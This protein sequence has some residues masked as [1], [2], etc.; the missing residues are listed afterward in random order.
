MLNSGAS[1]ADI[2]YHLTNFVEGIGLFCA[3]IAPTHFP[4][5]AHPEISVDVCYENTACL[6]TWQ[7]AGGRQLTRL[8]GDGN[9]SIIGSGQ[10]HGS[11][12]LQEA[13][14]LIFYLT[15]AFVER[16]TRDLLRRG[17]VEIVENR[18]A[19][20]PLIRQLAGTLRSEL[21]REHPPERLYV[22]SLVNVLAVH[23]LRTY[24]AE[25]K[26]LQEPRHGL[27]RGKL[28][29]VAHYV[30]D[31]LHEDLSLATLAGMAGLSPYHFSRQFKRAT[32]T[33]PHQYI[34]LRR[35]ERARTLLSTPR[36][37]LVTIANTVGFT[38]QSHLTHHV[39]RHF[40]VAPSAL[41]Q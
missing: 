24:S 39:R 10:P 36:L 12:W 7:T 38:H 1:G 37:S 26:A 33:T 8:L 11:E 41:R 13:E 23:L 16:A 40:G 2:P 4:E 30:L 14:H 15:P 3:A 35:G 25:N 34:V 32:G 5:H 29:R 9:V 18:S 28:E 20:D 22:E 27:S 31:H 21:R 19:D 17:S 6:S